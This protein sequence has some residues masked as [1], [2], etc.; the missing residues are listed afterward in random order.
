MDRKE[1]E[2][3]MDLCDMWSIRAAMVSIVSFV[4]ALVPLAFGIKEVFL[5]LVVLSLGLIGMAVMLLGCSMIYSERY[6]SEWERE[7]WR[8]IRRR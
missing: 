1:L 6:W 3:R 8:T 5:G 7:F 2:R 4:A